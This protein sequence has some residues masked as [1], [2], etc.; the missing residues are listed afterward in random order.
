M[1]DVVFIQKIIDLMTVPRTAR[2]EHTQSCK[3][4]VPAD[5]ASP[6]DQRVHDWLA[7]PWHAG[8]HA[9][10]FSGRHVE[11]LAVVRCHSC[12]GERRCAL[13]HR[14]I[15][16]EIALV[17]NGEFLFDVVPS[18]EDLYFATQNNSQPDVPLPRLIHHVSALDDL[19]SSEWFEQR[20]LM[21]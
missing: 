12:G 9:P 14:H 6:H 16:D 10:E 20:K 3:F 18:L 4:A 11:D 7:N 13:Q 1:R 5:S 2:S 15:A 21:I 8:Q 17:R 19:T